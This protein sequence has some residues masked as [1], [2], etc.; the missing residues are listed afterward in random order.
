[1]SVASGG[2]AVA[3]VEDAPSEY[4]TPRNAAIRAGFVSLDSV[5]VVD[6][7]RSRPVVMKSVLAFFR[8]VPAMFCALRCES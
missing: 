6:L 3:S 4:I 1:M 7:F 2:A 8:G 5:N